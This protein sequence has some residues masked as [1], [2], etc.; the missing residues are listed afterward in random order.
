MKRVIAIG[1]ETRTERGLETDRRR[2]VKQSSL[3]F[4]LIVTCNGARAGQCIDR[5]ED[6]SLHVEIQ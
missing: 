4:F 1:R 5:V 2:Q 6:N 3:T